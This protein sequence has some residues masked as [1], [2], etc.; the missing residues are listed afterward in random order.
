[1]KRIAFIS[2]LLAIAIYFIF[3]RPMNEVV[4][5]QYQP[6]AKFD[7]DIDF[8]TQGFEY[9]NGA[10]YESSGL[11]GASE[12]R[13]TQISTGEI[14][15][16]RSLDELYFGEG[17]TIFEDQIFQLTWQS[18]KGFIYD[19]KTLELIGEFSVNG[20]GWGL[21][22]DGQKLIMSNGSDRLIFLDPK[23]LEP[24]GEVSVK[25]G[26]TPQFL[27]NELEFINGD[28][29]ANIW[30][31]D[32]IVVV[33][34]ST[35]NVKSIIDLSNFSERRNSHDVS[36]GIAFNKNHNTVYVTGKNWSHIYALKLDKKKIYNRTYFS[37]AITRFGFL[38]R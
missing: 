26:G 10:F 37:R 9:R 7:H 30:K 12:L 6:I 2:L 15:Q 4:V 33:D 27:L 13:V 32:Q 3:L 29:W 23:T 36:N 14:L 20:E 1:M 31:D 25:L 19:L 22:N 18:G 34:L 11:R 38:V 8:F 16:K 35:G 17:I 24:T 28:V 21:T 5:Y